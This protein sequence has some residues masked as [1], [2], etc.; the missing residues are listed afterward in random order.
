[1]K[2]ILTISIIVS[3]L[4]VTNGLAQSGRDIMQMVK[5]RPDGDT[6][7]SEMTM[8]LINKRGSVRERKLIS[9]STDVGKGKK[10]RK[11]IMFFLYPGDVKGTGF[12]T[13]DY[14]EIGKDDDK[15]LY[16]PAMKKTRRIS[17]SSAQKDYFMGSDFTY[18]DMGSRN[19]D[20]DTHNLLGEEIIDGQKCWKIESISKDKRDVFSRKIAWIRQDCHLPVKVEYYDKMD[21]LH[22]RL[23]LSDIKKIDG[24]WT[25]QRMQM[26]NEQSEHKTILEFS[27]TKFNIPVDESKFSVSTLEKGSL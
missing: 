11:T 20:E 14:D 17:G 12:L 2:K 1:M 15:W 26:S 4:A 6:R 7:Q 13:W 10:D 23:V 19:V 24:F 18:D 27:N 21:K 22:R 8:K 5:D 3:L 9:Y 25:A 16:L